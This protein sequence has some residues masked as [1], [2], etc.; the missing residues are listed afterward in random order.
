VRPV[1]VDAEEV[2]RGADD[3]QVV[4][5]DQRVRW[6]QLRP[7]LGRVGAVQDRVHVDTVVLGVHSDHSGVG[8]GVERD[9]RLR[10]HRRSQLSAGRGAGT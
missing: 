9:E 6:Q 4:V 10:V 3:G 5:V 1:V 7:S 8:I 2:D